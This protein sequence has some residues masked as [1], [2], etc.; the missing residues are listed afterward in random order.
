MRI[1][2]LAAPLAVVLVLA[3]APAP[4]GAQI[5][6]SPVQDYIDKTTL[7]NG[8][9]SNARA[10]DMSQR[11]QRDAAR[12]REAAAFFQSLLD[13]YRKTAA[14]DGFPAN[15]VAYAM[16][17]FVVNGYMT[18]HD[19]HDVPYEKDPRV[20]RGAQPLDRVALAA[21]KQEL[22][23]ALAIGFGTTYAAYMRGVHA[24]DEALMAQARRTAGEQLERLVG[25]PAARIRIDESG[26]HR[27]R[28]LAPAAAA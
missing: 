20:R 21:E 5:G 25:A 16:E 26:L 14:T 8:I 19:L 11:A 7:L 13:L 1:A 27:S 10:T 6:L 24:G 4:A 23:E 12:R 28:R 3:A 15:D 9:L 17:Y 2:P 18:Y 22:A